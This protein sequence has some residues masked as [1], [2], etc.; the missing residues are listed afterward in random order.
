MLCRGSGHLPQ[1]LGSMR[2][3]IAIV[4]LALGGC[5]TVQPPLATAV[6]LHVVSY[7]QADGTYVLT[8]ENRS[9]KS[10]SYL[11][12]F[13]SYSRARDPGPVGYPTFPPNLAVMLHE[14]RLEPGTM[15]RIEGVCASTEACK[16]QSTYAGIYACWLT[17]G[18]ECRQY[19]RVWSDRP[20]N[21]A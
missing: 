1:A 20:L 14:A 9:R 18:S 21:G 8:L 16:E 7:D 17:A 4:G 5:A 6:S 10:V 2:K 13:V 11:S 12:Y 19:I 15:S 3:W